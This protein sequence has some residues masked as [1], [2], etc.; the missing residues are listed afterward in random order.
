MK[1]DEQANA[2]LRVALV[3]QGYYIGG[4]V[5]SVAR[6][7][8]AGLQA[9]GRFD[10]EV[11]DLATT[12]VGTANRRLL[13][14]TTWFRRSLRGATKEGVHQWGANGSE[15][16]FM[17]YRPRRELTRVL[18]KFDVVQVVAGSPALGRA[19][20]KVS[21]PV[22]LQVA[23]TVS[24]ERTSRLRQQS[25]GRRWWG[26]LMTVLVSRQEVTALRS[27]DAVLVENQQ[28]W[29]YSRSVGQ[30]CTW[31]APPGVDTA[32]YVPHPAGWDG[33]RYFLSLCRLG[34]ERKGLE[35][36][37]AAYAEI[38]RIA[39]QS[40]KLVL[41][42]RG[43]VRPTVRAAIE[44]FDLSERVEIRR[45]IPQGELPAI[46]ANASIFF[47]TSFEEGLGLSVVEAMAAGLPVV[48]TTT[49]G[50]EETVE[51]GVTGWLVDQSDE[52][53]LV[54]KFAEKVLSLL[55]GKGSSFAF[56]AR[57]RAVRCFDS[58]TNLEQFMRVY[59]SL[60]SRES[61]R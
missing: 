19:L 34:E 11:F 25:A 30:T 39:P 47:Q 42:G 1:A 44:K 29:D 43:D 38:V 57:S 6:W 7:L 5:P 28:M 55:A 4:G 53:D 18:D 32:R 59:D 49:A 22:C 13:R 45:D 16:E 8:R 41:A 15:L 23:T 17:R 9:S 50:S 51:D 33:S 27:A 46:L 40:P 31:I 26:R 24:W 52:N 2:P 58:A 48:A 37:I 10:V 56:A 20:V 60:V 36:T 14:P 12:G 21:R 54:G 61:G 3:T 35:R